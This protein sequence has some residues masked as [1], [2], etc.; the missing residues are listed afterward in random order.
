MLVLT[1]KVGQRFILQN[2]IT[3]KRLGFIMLSN[4][5][6]GGA[7]RFGF[8]LSDDIEVIREEL[9]SADEDLTSADCP[10]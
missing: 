6:P 2:K 1:R 8:D 5:Q 3:G 10:A 7:A 9:E 4:I